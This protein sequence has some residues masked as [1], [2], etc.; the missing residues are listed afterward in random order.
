M[1]THV[2]AG[3]QDDNGWPSGRDSLRREYPLIDSS[4]VRC[5]EMNGFSSEGNT[6]TKLRLIVENDGTIRKQ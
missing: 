6:L 1:R 3:R 2:S 4:D 5:D